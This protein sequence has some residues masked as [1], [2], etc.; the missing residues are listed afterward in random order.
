MS[1]SKN[2]RLCFDRA[3]F[4]LQSNLIW[5][6]NSFLKAYCYRSH[7]KIQSLS[8]FIRLDFLRKLICC[9]WH[10]VSIF[11]YF[12]LNTERISFARETFSMQAF[13]FL[14]LKT[15]VL[16]CLHLHWVEKLG[17]HF[18]VKNKVTLHNQKILT[19][20]ELSSQD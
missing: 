5:N 3:I 8:S 17:L 15:L 2:K 1:K 16:N 18:G 19:I 12:Y 11:I 10:F 9:C 6:N 7:L 4:Y 14:T 13:R 20:I